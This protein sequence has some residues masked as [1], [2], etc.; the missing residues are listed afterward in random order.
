MRDPKRIPKVLKAIERYWELHPD[1][2]LGQ[3]VSNAHSTWG[4]R[5]DKGRLE[6]WDANDVFYFEDDDLL[7]T[8]YEE[9]L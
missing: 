1:L 8:I 5:N 7:K 9:L 4:V 3:I 2:R 6:G